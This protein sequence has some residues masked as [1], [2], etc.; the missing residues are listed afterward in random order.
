MSIFVTPPILMYLRTR[1]LNLLDQNRVID[2]HNTEGLKLLTRMRLRVSHL[3]DHKLDIVF[4]L[5]VPNVSFL[6]PLKTSQ[7]LPVF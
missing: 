2:I 1:Y 3:A 4:N 7:N 5:F 6:Y